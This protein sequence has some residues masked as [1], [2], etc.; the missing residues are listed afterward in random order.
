M[1]AQLIVT[2][3]WAV[4]EPILLE[5]YEALS[6]QP[7]AEL[8]EPRVR[9]QLEEAVVIREEAARH[10]GVVR[11]LERGRIHLCRLA[12]VDRRELCSQLIQA[13]LTDAAVELCVS[14]ARELLELHGDLVIRALGLEHSV[15]THLLIKHF[16]FLPARTHTASAYP[17]PLAPCWFPL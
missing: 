15:R 7:P 9:R 13:G 11:G 10:V 16:R 2:A 4:D 1:P 12:V 5:E 8:E 17:K 14:D 6:K 3:R